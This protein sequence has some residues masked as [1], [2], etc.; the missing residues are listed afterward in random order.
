MKLTKPIIFFVLE[1]E[2]GWSIDDIEELKELFAKVKNPLEQ[3]EN[4]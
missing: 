2:T 3:L 1:T 4:K